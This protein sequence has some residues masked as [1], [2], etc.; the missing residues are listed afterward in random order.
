MSD[1]SVTADDLLKGL[2]PSHGILANNTT[3]R[4]PTKSCAWR[5]VIAYDAPE[6]G[7]TSWHS[8]SARPCAGP[9][10]ASLITAPGAPVPGRL[11]RGNAMN[12]QQVFPPDTPIEVIRLC[13]QA[14]AEVERQAKPPRREW[15]PVVV[16]AS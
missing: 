12:E 4:N 3:A 16:R 14:L 11:F 8:A 9:R 2:G 15:R 5:L 10:L 6:T 1:G 7:G 13:I